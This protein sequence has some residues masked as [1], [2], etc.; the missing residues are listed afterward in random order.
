MT[1]QQRKKFQQNPRPVT[2]V[3]VPASRI[4]WGTPRITGHSRLQIVTVE[5]MDVLESGHCTTLRPLSSPGYI[6]RSPEVSQPGSGKPPNAPPLPIPCWL[7]GRTWQPFTQAFAPEVLG[8]CVR[9]NVE[10]TGLI[11]QDS[12][13]LMTLEKSLTLSLMYFTMLSQGQ[14]SEVDHVLGPH[15]G[16]WGGYKWSKYVSGRIQCAWFIKRM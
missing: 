10:A 5:K 7:P 2:Q 15:W 1:L 16:E 8:H 9:K 3:G 6:C 12:S 4:T 13:I 11:Q 14:N